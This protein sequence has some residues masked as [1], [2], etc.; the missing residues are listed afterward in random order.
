VKEAGPSTPVLIMGWDDVPTAGD[1]FEAVKNEKAA[2][3]L[4]SDR[5]DDLRAKELVV[6]TA[7][8][9]L[10][11]LV[12]QLRTADQ[13]EL[14]VVVKA[15]AHGS[16]EAIREAIAK[17]KREDARVQVI[18]GAVGGI[19]ANDVMLAEV[20]DAIIYG[21]NTRPDAGARKAAEEH[22]IEIR[23]FRV[24]YELLDDIEQV[25]VGQLEPE[26]IEGILGVAE[27][28][29]TF[30]APR[31]G[32][33]AG[34]YITEGEIVRNARARLVRD[35]VVVYDGRIGSLRRFK[36]DVRTVAT[37][38]ECGIGLENYRDIKE[39]DLIEAYEVREVART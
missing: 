8:E 27:V 23:A 30:R 29:E 24:I 6:P 20:S 31:F 18:H 7:Q 13:S 38:F 1:M 37:G 2:R 19:S 26:E 11:Q 34:C 21:F 3:A 33:V 28:R 17:I 9:R 32:L 4:A 5:V 35:G 10:A 36:D 39:G 25:L 15:D 16:L 14:N 12:E 22:G